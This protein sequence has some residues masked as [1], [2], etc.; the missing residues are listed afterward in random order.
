MKSSKCLWA[1][2]LVLFLIVGV[3]SVCP[4]FAGL[5]PFPLSPN[6]RG[7]VTCLENPAIRYDIALPPAYATNFPPLPIL[8]TMHPNGGGMVSYFQTVCSSLNIIAVGLINSSNGA[9]DNQVFRDFYAVTRDIRQRVAFDPTAEFVGGF[10][11]GGDASYAFSRFRAQHVAGVF[12]MGA[13]LGRIGGPSIPVV[14]YSTD[15]VQTNLL[16]ARSTGNSDTG[17][18][19][20][21]PP[22]SNY[23]ASCGAVVQDWFVSGGHNIS[24]PDATKTAALTWLVNTRIHPEASDRLNALTQVANWQTRIAAGQQESVF[25]ECVNT[26]MTRPRSYFAYQAQFIV[27]QL[28]TNYTS[29]R[30]L[31]L[32]N[33][34]KGDFASDLFYYYARGAATNND[35]QRYYSALKALTGITGSSGD[36]AGDIYAQLLQAGY[37]APMLQCSA[38]RTSGQLNLWLNKD[39]PGLAYSVQSRSNLVNDVWLDIPVSGLDTN[40]IWSTGIPLQPETPDIFYRV[41]AT[42]VP[43]TSPPWPQ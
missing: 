31:N 27:D 14:Y 11:G 21:N 26:L 43:A 22:D 1:K 42:P 30:T 28:T 19:F 20:Y 41:G 23:L 34:A 37:P 4:A 36:R 9:P 32:T 2:C 3:F 12:A 25:R 40:T 8:Y 33:L 24:I 6:Q 29:F 15:R 16:V 18:I 17:A 13:W 38:S 5:L 39:A 35:R 7:T 10:S